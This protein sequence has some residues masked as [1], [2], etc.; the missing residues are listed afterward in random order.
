MSIEEGLNAHLRDHVD[1]VSERVYPVTAPQHTVMPYLTYRRISTPQDY[2]HDG[3]TG[4]HRP[5]FQIDGYGKHFTDVMDIAAE[6]RAALSGHVGDL[7]TKPVQACKIV[8]EHNTY[9]YEA[10]AHRVIIDVIIWYQY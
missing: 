8:S 6:V 2:A 9:E 4:L 7:D 10:E 1:S 5:R 3:P